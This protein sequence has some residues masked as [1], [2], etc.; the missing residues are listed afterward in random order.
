MTVVAGGILETPIALLRRIRYRHRRTAAFATYAAASAVAY[1][2][3]FLLRFEF[4]WPSAYTA[5]FLV[6]LPLLLV[7]RHATHQGF[8]LSTS[9]WRYASVGDVLRLVSGAFVGSVVFYAVTR[10]PFLAEQ[11][12][13]S[14]IALEGLL[15]VLLIAAVWICYRVAFE[16]VRYRRASNGRSE[17][18]VLIIGAGESG[19]I[20]AREM[21]RQMTGYR[22][23]GFVDDDPHKWGTRLAGLE[24][25]GATGEL[26]QIAL[27]HRIEELILAVPH[28]T[29]IQM[30]AIVERCEATNLPYRVLPSIAAVLAGDVRLDQIREVRIEDLL[31]REPVQLELQELAEDLREGCALITGA[32]GSIGSELSRQIALHSPAVLVLLDQAETDLY[33]LELELREKYP[34]L[35]IVPIIGDVVDSGSVEPVFQRY[36]PTH[37]FHAAAYKHVPMM[38]VNVREAVRNN[39]IGTQTIASAAGRYGARKFVLVSTDKAV[40][41]VSV[42]GAT[43]R[44][45]EMVSLNLQRKHP[46]TIYA[47]VRFGNVLGSNGSVIPL[48]RRQLEAGK[49]LTVTHPDVTRYFM[50]IPEAVQ[51]VLHASLLPEIRGHIAMLEMGEPVRIVDLAKNL[52]RLSGIRSASRDRLV[53]TGLRP[54]EKLHEELIAPEEEAIETAI[55]KVR[56]V[57]TDEVF[58]RL[59]RECLAELERVI[60]AGRDSEIIDVLAAFFPNLTGKTR[61]VGLRTPRMPAIVAGEISV[62]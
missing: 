44:L 29:P 28:A 3:A 54:G 48:F 60:H 50:T 55:P 9:R 31:G 18:R 34:H 20:L 33:Y 51:L 5:T 22:P 4:A 52:L 13:V 6:T 21:L 46:K 59:G 42:M 10:V 19:Y 45:A 62:R 49:P 37:V 27:A 58:D 40:R 57:R 14:V 25:F 61:E 39:V 47:A 36:R 16:T 38:E 15:T 26:P 41:P 23:I 53:F 35:H 43:K 24:V 32:A 56:L 2:L 7:I 12:P 1:L 8:R 11:V 30:R 17:R